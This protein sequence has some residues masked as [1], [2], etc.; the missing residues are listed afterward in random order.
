MSRDI[1]YPSNKLYFEKVPSD[2]LQDAHCE[3]T[4]HDDATITSEG[5]P[6]FAGLTPSAGTTVTGR[7]TVLPTLELKGSQPQFSQESKERYEEVAAL[8]EGASGEVV[9]AQDHDIKRMVAVKKL[10]NGK[11]SSSALARFVEEIQTVGTLEHPNIVPI[12]DVGLDASGQFFFVMKYV[13][14]ETLRQI[15]DKLRAGDR[16]YQKR[17]PIEVRNNIFLKIMQ[18]IQYAHSQGIIHRDLKPDNVI[19]GPFGEVMVMDWGIAKKIGTPEQDRKIADTIPG[20]D[21]VETPRERLFETQ[22]GT[23][24]GTPAYMSPEQAIGY[25][26]TLDERT[27][28]Y[29]LAVL[30]Y[31]MIGLKH[32]LEHKRDL[33]SMLFGVAKEKE[34]MLVANLHRNQD[35]IPVELCH[36]VRIG[37]LKERDQRYQNL[38][39]MIHA[40]Q[41]TMAGKFDAHCPVSFT[42]VMGNNFLRFVDKRPMSSM[43]MLLSV[44]GFGI[45]GFAQMLVQFASAI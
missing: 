24:L 25:H 31:E 18:A 22:L 10:K 15:I 40:F 4:L 45:F 28:I 42:K 34:V 27:D 5:S 44:V 30:Y 6:D 17:F 19:V 39:E 14:G 3:H 8:G 7:T 23:I 1:Y 41:L 33:S 29:S 26:S 43:M 9:L 13:K 21:T 38:E 37:M 36:F 32:Y 12:H 20:F 35:P 11:E 16:A 2:F